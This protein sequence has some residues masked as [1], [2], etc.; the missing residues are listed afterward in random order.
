MP[1]CSE[2]YSIA[3]LV[4]AFS[5]V[6][7]ADGHD[8][9]LHAIFTEINDNKENLSS[10]AFMEVAAT[11]YRLHCIDTWP[12]ARTFF[13]SMFSRLLTEPAKV[14]IDIGEIKVVLSPESIEYL[15]TQNN[16]DL[17]VL[18]F[19]TCEFM[20][21][22]EEAAEADEYAE[23]ASCDDSSEGSSDESSGES[24]GDS[25]EDVD[26]PDDDDASDT[27]VETAN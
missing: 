8:A 22:A 7:H 20:G 10:N 17:N 16:Y 14:D 19:N 9:L 1:I 25:N 26:D 11:L 24:S 6:K 5:A 4:G 2:L 27:A 12:W 3:P 21:E 15:C 18:W 23:D 13:F